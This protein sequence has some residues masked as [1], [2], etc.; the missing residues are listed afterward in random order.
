V[1]G[2][3]EGERPRPLAHARGLGIEANVLTPPETAK[4]EPNLRMTIAGSVYYP[5]DCHL[6]PQPLLAT[7]AREVTHGADSVLALD[8]AKF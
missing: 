1:A 5:M 3:P 4:I 7:L 8:P 2:A 6:S